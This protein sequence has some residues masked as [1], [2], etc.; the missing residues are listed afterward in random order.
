M[1]EREM[2][3]ICRCEGCPGDCWCGGLD[4]DLRPLDCGCTHMREA[5]GDCCWAYTRGAR[6]NGKQ[7]RLNWLRRRLTWYNNR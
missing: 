3:Q 7:S 5:Y 2:T 6:Q 4:P 1:D